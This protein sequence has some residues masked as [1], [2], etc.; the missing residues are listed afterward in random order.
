M[1]RALS[2]QFDRALQDYAIWQAVPEEERSPAPAWW[3]GPALALRDNS[4]LLPPD[5][6]EQL[7]LPRHSNYGAAARQLLAAIE[8]QTTLPWPDEF[9]RK[10]QPK[11]APSEPGIPPST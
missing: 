3:W 10:Y 6:A 8:E 11:P 2:F 9:P 5:V 1:N 4:E 7:R